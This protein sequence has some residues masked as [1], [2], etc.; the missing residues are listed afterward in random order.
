MSLLLEKPGEVVTREELRAFLWGE[1]THVDFEHGLNT[2]V[3][4]L[5]RALGD[6]AESPI[7]I[8][9]VPGRG[10]RLIASSERIEDSRSAASHVA[11]ASNLV[12]RVSELPFVGREAELRRLGL[13][14]SLACEQRGGVVLLAGEP[15]IGKTRLAEE[16]GRYA[17]LRGAFVLAGRCVQ[18]E[19]A[20]LY[21][22]FREALSA[23][24]R[25]DEGALALAIQS[26]E[27]LSV[28]ATIAPA[29]RE[30]LQDLPQA[31]ALPGDAGR[32]R[33]ADALKQLFSDLVKRAPLVLL[34]DDL[35]RADPSTLATLEEIARS[36]S[37]A[38]FLLVAAYQDL[39]VGRGHPL[40]AAR[41]AFARLELFDQLE[42]SGLA[43]ESVHD[44][45]W[46]VMDSQPAPGAV[47]AL[48]SATNGNPYLLREIL[49]QRAT[50]GDPSSAVG[51]STAALQVPEGVRVVLEQRL[52]KLSEPARRLLAA[53]SAFP[54]TF[55]L[56][57][58]AQCAGIGID[59][60]L[61]GLDEALEAKLV[62]GAGSSDDYAFWNT[63]IRQVL[64]EALAPA[65]RARLHRALGQAMQSDHESRAAVRA[66]AIAEQFWLSR[67]LPGAA[68]GVGAALTAAERAEAASDPETAARFLAMTLDLLPSGDPRR[69]SVQ[70]RLAQA[71]SPSG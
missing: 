69:R 2:A 70:G 52:Q 45:A 14:L 49:R 37:C 51:P 62:R 16:F 20:P 53:A 50:A 71:V 28:V 11:V 22:A 29:L 56:E 66:G 48:A 47:S 21:A 9:T 67:E 12:S 34:I 19:W 18:G 39:E 64:Y 31:A 24:A 32:H 6:S 26:R 40:V 44:L 54:G 55:H 35:H 33:L 23:F 7:F 65:R 1:A 46:A 43:Q 5:R 61:A 27:V 36:L 58:A 13:R 68:A 8:E 15:G 41:A 3:R 63:L 59:D 60:A 17:R 4:K 30:R 57:A 42:L 25:G 38:A 10:Y